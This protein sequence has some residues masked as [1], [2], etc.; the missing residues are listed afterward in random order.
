MTNTSIGFLGFGKM[1]MAIV[2]GWNNC[3]LSQDLDIFAYAPNQ[4]KLQA[5]CKILKVTPC[6]SARE[7]CHAQVLI[8]ACKPYQ[9]ESV[10][11]EISP[12]LTGKFVICLA[13]GIN[14]DKLQ[15]WIP[16]VH[17]V[18]IM[19]N[20]AMA[21][22]AGIAIVEKNNSMNE[23]EKVLFDTLFSPLALIEVVETTLFGIAGTISGCS[24]AFLGLYAEA[25]ADAGVKYGLSRPMAQRLSAR[26]V[27]GAGAMLSEEN[28]EPAIF[29]NEICSPGGTTIKGIVALEKAG[30]RKAVIEAI[31]AIEE[32]K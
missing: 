3:K 26:A 31:E 5:N 32:A 1:A 10:L 17:H 24:P 23:K 15:A 18:S 30:F 12:E 21:V 6:S 28:K 22:C 25:L 13:A 20:T 14:Y 7:A 8:L 27:Y 16:N 29:K 11:K 19:P 2:E 4:E 9:V